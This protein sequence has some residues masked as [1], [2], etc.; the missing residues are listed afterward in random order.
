M[1]DEFVGEYADNTGS[2][3][4]VTKKVLKRAWI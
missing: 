3:N 4:L 2:E 1:K